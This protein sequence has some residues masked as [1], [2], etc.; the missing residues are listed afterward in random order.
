MSLMLKNGVALATIVAI[1]LFFGCLNLGPT[2]VEE[3]TTFS[4]FNAVNATPANPGIVQGTIE[5]NAGIDSVMVTV[6]DPDGARFGSRSIF[7]ANGKTSYNLTYSLSVTAGDCMGTYTVVVVAY[8]VGMSTTKTVSVTVSG[9]KDCTTKVPVLTVGSLSGSGA[10][11]PS[12]PAILTATVTCTNCTATPSAIARV[13][14]STG[15]TVAGVS[16]VASYS[17]AASVTVTA[18]QTACNGTY[19]VTLTVSSGAL[20]QTRTSLVTVSGATDCDAPTGDLTVGAGLVL[21]AQNNAAGS[22][23]DIDSFAILTS[24]KAKT[25][26]ASVDCIAGYS[27]AFDSIRIGSPKWARDNAFAVASGWS[28]YNT[29]VFK[30]VQTRIDM[31]TAMESAM[32]TAWGGGSGTVSS[33]SCSVG[34]QFLTVTTTGAIAVIEVTAVTKGASGSVTVKIGRTRAGVE[35]PPVPEL[36]AILTETSLSVGADENATLGS[37]IDLDVPAV[38]LSTAAR[39]SAAQ[40]DLVYANSFATSS[41]KLGSPLWAQNNVSFVTGWAVYNDTKF[42]KPAGTSYE[43]VSTPDQL[44][45]LWDVSKATASS[46]DVVAN[47]VIIAKTNQGAIVLIKIVT[48]TPGATG[49][50]DIK[51]AK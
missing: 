9:A 1:G 24:E 35:T 47:D 27:V 25:S 30:A 40:V 37:S 21:G 10:V 18:A 31:K 2:G 26:A 4:G 43:S 28:I 14:D 6:T 7:N 17:S 39:N 12:T 33:F 15:A 46:I 19:T 51:V 44:K 11:T 34:K 20:S 38:L 5:N 48:Q 36:P 29:N 45:N 22:S 41:D 16:A 23:L 50:I 3:D 42:Y 8:A 13:T 49:R 32:K